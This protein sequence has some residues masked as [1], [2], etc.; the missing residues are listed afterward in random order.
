MISCA[1]EALALIRLSIVGVLLIVLT[2]G[3]AG[4]TAASS[5]V[6]QPGTDVRSLRYADPEDW[7]LRY[8]SSLVLEHS[9]G[10]GPG[11]FVAEVTVANFTQTCAIAPDIDFADSA[12]PPLDPAGRFP[13]NGVA[14]RM[15]LVQGNASA[16]KSVL[17]RN[18]RL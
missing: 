13:S 1:R 9:S 11:L 14:F 8:P 7:S 2:A 4:G 6:H 5:G 3:C 15:L 16:K 18:S 17:D 12:R 10:G